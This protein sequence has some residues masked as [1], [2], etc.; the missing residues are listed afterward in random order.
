MGRPPPLIEM[1][2]EGIHLQ[3]Y[4]NINNRNRINDEYIQYGTAAALLW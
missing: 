2:A 4:A 3:N 1:F